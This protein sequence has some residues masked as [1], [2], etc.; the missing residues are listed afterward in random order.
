[1]SKK[2][3]PEPDEFFVGYLPNAP[4][5][6]MSILKWVMVMV[7]MSIV[8]IGIVLVM[9]QR[10]FS[11]SNFD[12][13]KYTSVEGFIFKSPIPHIKISERTE[14]GDTHHRTMLLVGFGKAGADK[15]LLEFEEKL[16]SL[17]G[18][19]VKLEGELIYGDNK[20]LFQISKDRAPE[21]KTS[22]DTVSSSMKTQGVV[23]VS[24]EI[25][26]PKCYFGV[27]KPG[28]GKPHRSCAI[29]CI[30][31]GIPPVFHADGKSDYYILLDENLKPV[32]DR[33]LDMVGD[34]ITLSGEVIL[35]DNWKIL[36][37]K[38]K[39]LQEQAISAK[40]IRNLIAMEK[41]MTTC[42]IN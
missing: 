24:G 26:D 10:E 17:N 21:I 22:I 19:F 4:V 32:N 30:A 9:S 23:S 18:K 27:M 33:V 29:R 5:K 3:V 25:I 39:N 41:G 7:G 13:G 20:S 2:I 36:L 15:T 37:V 8:I 16:G 6:T 40:L 38:N 31:G 42:G 14:S 12:Y 35:F 28:E 34:R 11:S 1:M